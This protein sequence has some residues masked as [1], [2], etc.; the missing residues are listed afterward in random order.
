LVGG[1][2]ASEDDLIKHCRASLAGYE[3]PKSVVLVFSVMATG[4]CRREARPG[5]LVP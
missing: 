4:A 3:T 2:E 1:A 5:M